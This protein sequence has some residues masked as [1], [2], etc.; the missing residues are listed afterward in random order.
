MKV[1]N[2]A[3]KQYGDYILFDEHALVVTEMKLCMDQV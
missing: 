2:K 3:Y 1:N